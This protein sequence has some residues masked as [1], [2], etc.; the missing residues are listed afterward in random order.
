MIKPIVLVLLVGSTSVA[1][2]KQ[3]THRLLEWPCFNYMYECHGIRPDD[4]QEWV[5]AKI[6]V[7][8]ILNSTRACEKMFTDYQLD[9]K[10]ERE[11]RTSKRTSTLVFTKVTKTDRMCPF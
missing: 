2:L 9:G 11:I 4:K 1:L 3:S 8:Y 5:Y 7:P 6:C 10:C